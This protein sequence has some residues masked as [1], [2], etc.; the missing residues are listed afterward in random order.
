MSARGWELIA[1]DESAILAE[2]AF[3]AFIVE[4]RQ[5]DGCLSNPSGTDQGDWRELL[6][7]TGDL[8]DQLIPSKE[9]PS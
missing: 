6:C 3:Y 2:P 4:G 1:A 7:Q 8:V 5:N 9:D